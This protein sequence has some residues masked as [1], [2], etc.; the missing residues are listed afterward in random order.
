ML[1][2]VQ[3]PTKSG[4]PLGT[5]GACF[6]GCIPVTKR[7]GRY[8]KLQERRGGNR[9]R[10]RKVPQNAKAKLSKCGFSCTGCCC[11]SPASGCWTSFQVGVVVFS[12]CNHH[13]GYSSAAGVGMGERQR[14]WPWHLTFPPL[15]LSLHRTPEAS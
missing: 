9:R 8:V 10:R 2:K 6:Q 1:H 15:R 5:A 7:A 4:A 11:A 13:C 12:S 3:A 14:T